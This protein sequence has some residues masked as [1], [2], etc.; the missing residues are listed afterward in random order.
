MD[1]KDTNNTFI[2][3]NDTPLTEKVCAVIFSKE[4]NSGVW[5]TIEKVIPPFESFVLHKHEIAKIMPDVAQGSI[6]LCLEAQGTF[7]DPSRF[8]K[9]FVANWISS[10]NNVTSGAMT[11]AGP[12][13]ELNTAESKKKKSFTMFAP[14]NYEKN[15]VRS[16]N[17][18][19]NHSTD[20]H[21]AD[22]VKLEP[23]LHNL[24]GQSV[25]GEPVTIPPF[26]VAIIDMEKCF[27][28]EGV[29]L[30]TKTHGYGTITARYVGYIFVSYFFQTDWQ[31][32]FLCGNHT[33]P[34]S[35]IFA[36]KIP[37]QMLKSK[38]KQA[39]PFLIL[40]RR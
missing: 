35:G 38:I 1:A 19:I 21:Y 4:G 18:I 16:Y 3:E 28:Q 14:V 30:L 10:R 5:K 22:T 9:E 8:R 13:A 25:K 2:Y 39:L 11:S 37:F 26:G 17:V 23:I 33:Q 12:F 7:D 31:G 40:L 36:K 6:L 34:P 32:N 20:P 29:D 15:K 27:G 24:D